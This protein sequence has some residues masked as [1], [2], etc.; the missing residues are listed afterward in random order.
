M[1]YLSFRVKRKVIGET[2]QEFVI[3][4]KLHHILSQYLVHYI[5]KFVKSGFA[6]TGKKIH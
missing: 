1:S 2:P 6:I 4:E 5:R 3:K